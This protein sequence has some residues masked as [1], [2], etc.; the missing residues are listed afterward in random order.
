MGRRDT[1]VV[2][3]HSPSEIE[4]ASNFPRKP[5]FPRAIIAQTVKGYGVD[6]LQGHGQWHHKVPS[7]SEMSQIRE[8]LKSGENSN[9]S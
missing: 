9:E 7:D 3:G 2:D 5:G 8:L 6:F 4:Y 1:V